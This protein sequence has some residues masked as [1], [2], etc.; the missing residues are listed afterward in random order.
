MLFTIH[1]SCT[2]ASQCD[3]YDFLEK[4]NTENSR[5]E[6]CFLG[7]DLQRLAPLSSL[8]RIIMLALAA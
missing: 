5:W 2:I 8:N 7:I 3:S 1:S 4:Q 6:L